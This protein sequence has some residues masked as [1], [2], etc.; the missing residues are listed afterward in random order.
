[1]LGVEEREKTKEWRW[2]QEK[3][4]LRWRIGFTTRKRKKKKE[5]RRDT[6][7][8]WVDKKKKRKSVTKY[9]KGWENEV[10][11]LLTKKKQENK[12]K[13]KIWPACTIE[14]KNGK[15][16]KWKT[17]LML[18]NNNGGKM[19]RLENKGR[20]DLSSGN[21]WERGKEHCRKKN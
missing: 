5:H 10:D 17:K 19:E 3:P 2:E 18:K 7:L 1:M 11:N 20:S 9:R 12:N 21:S 13:R 14:K 6:R 15:K 4:K 16:K 8:A